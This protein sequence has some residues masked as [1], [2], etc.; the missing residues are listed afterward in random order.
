MTSLFKYDFRKDE[1]NCKI[2]CLSLIVISI[3]GKDLTLQIGN[4]QYARSELSTALAL[5]MSPEV[6]S[7]HGEGCR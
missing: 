1:K 5:V 4:G 6:V 7:Q 2:K 3:P